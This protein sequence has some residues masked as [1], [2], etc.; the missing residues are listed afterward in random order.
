[1]RNKRPPPPA[2][3]FDDETKKKQLWIRLTKCFHD[4]SIYC[5]TCILLTKG[6]FKKIPPGKHCNTLG[7]NVTYVHSKEG[8]KK[9]SKMKK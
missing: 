1:M 3:V 5:G 2:Q 8:V 6:N 9:Y 4:I 7:Y